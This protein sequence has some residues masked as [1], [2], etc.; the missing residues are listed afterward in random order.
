MAVSKCECAQFPRSHYPM[1]R[2]G[3][4]SSSGTAILLVCAEENRPGL[5]ENIQYMETFFKG[6]NLRINHIRIDTPLGLRS[7]LSV[8]TNPELER[9]NYTEVLPDNIWNARILREDSLCFIGIIANGNYAYTQLSKGAYVTDVN[10]EAFFNEDY[11]LLLRGKP[12]LFLYFK[13]YLELKDGTETVDL[14]KR[15]ASLHTGGIN[16]IN[17]ISSTN[18]NFLSYRIYDFGLEA[19]H[20]RS[21]ASIALMKLPIAYKRENCDI[22]TFFRL[23]LNEMITL[24]ETDQRMKNEHIPCCMC[25]LSFRLRYNLLFLQPLYQLADEEQDREN[26]SVEILPDPSLDSMS[27][28]IPTLV[29]EVSPKKSYFKS[30]LFSTHH[31]PSLNFSLAVNPWSSQQRS[32]RQFPLQPKV[33]QNN[34]EL[35]KVT[36]HKKMSCHKLNQNESAS[37]STALFSIAQNNNP[38]RVNELQPEKVGEKDHSLQYTPLNRKRAKKKRKRNSCV[39]DCIDKLGE[40][41]LISDQLLSTKKIHIGHASQ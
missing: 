22:L 17:T 1:S 6:L 20:T 11:C 21:S 41:D 37:S 2:K 7:A 24:I 40:I 31:V 34:G 32:E 14:I 12:K 36:H 19:L 28:D 9:S 26:E 8:I 23:F 35:T 39:P 13:Y 33:V 30:S 27:T 38:F 5:Q 29:P 16:W 3:P 25:I 10:I 15:S 4:D 18:L